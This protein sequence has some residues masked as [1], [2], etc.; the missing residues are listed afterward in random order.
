MPPNLKWCSFL[1]ALCPAEPSFPWFLLILISTSCNS[2]SGWD[3]SQARLEIPSLSLHR[4]PDCS[5]VR[6]EKLEP[7]RQWENSHPPLRSSPQVSAFHG[8]TGRE[9]LLQVKPLLKAVH[10]RS[11]MSSSFWAHGLWPTRLLCPWDFPGKNTGVDCHF[12]LQGIFLTQGWNPCLLHWEVDSLPLV[13]PRKPSLQL[14]S[15]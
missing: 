12:L 4:E 1:P 6:G 9:G 11:V 14:E 5:L 10:V 3:F 13:P 7:W 8:A 2:L 15:A